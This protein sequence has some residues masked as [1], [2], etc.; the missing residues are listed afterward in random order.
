MLRPLLL[1]QPRSTL[2][3]IFLTYPCLNV[4]LPQTLW[5]HVICKL[6]IVFSR[7]PLQN[8]IAT[9]DHT[10]KYNNIYKWDSSF[11]NCRR[12]SLCFKQQMHERK[13]FPKWKCIDT[14]Q[15]FMLFSL[16]QLLYSHSWT[17]MFHCLHVEVGATYFANIIVF[18]SGQWW[19]YI[20]YYK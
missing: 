18:L 16:Y 11:C 10:V 8:V 6:I 19:Q 5:E 3:M 2:W 9:L 1:K 4:Y 17:Q 13:H 15:Q 20:F 14:M 12:I 7:F